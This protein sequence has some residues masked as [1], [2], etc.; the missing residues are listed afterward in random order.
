MDII[1]LSQKLALRDRTVPSTSVPLTPPASVQLSLTKLGSR[2]GRIQSLF[3]HAPVKDVAVTVVWV[4]DL[5]EIPGRII[6]IK[7]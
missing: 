6:C 5:G 7:L 2:V 1:D 4:I 3:V